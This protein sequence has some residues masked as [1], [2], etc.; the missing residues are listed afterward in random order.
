MKLWEAMLS[1]PVRMRKNATFKQ[2]IQD[3]L[4]S[5]EDQFAAKE[6][7]AASSLDFVDKVRHII[8]PDAELSSVKAWIQ[9]FKEENITFHG[10]PIGDQGVRTFQAAAPYADRPEA[11][12]AA[13]PATADEGAGGAPSQGVSLACVGCGRQPWQLGKKKFQVCPWCAEKKLPATFWCGKDCP[14]NPEA[15]GKHKAWHKELK[16]QQERREDGGVAQQRNRELAE[17]DAALARRPEELDGVEHLPE[18]S[19]DSA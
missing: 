2:V 4:T 6:A 5:D 7:T 14:A 1:M 18:A 3:I 8:S 13:T 17:R 16:V 11:T 9:R 19:V 15:W 10:V 12:A